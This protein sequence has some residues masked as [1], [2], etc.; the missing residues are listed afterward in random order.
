MWEIL[1]L[2][3]TY[4]KFYAKEMW[5]VLA[6]HSV[7]IERERDECEW[8]VLLLRCMI[9]IRNSFCLKS[10]PDDSYFSVEGKGSIVLN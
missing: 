8:T 10:S 7:Y 4:K 5:L 9:K 1:I 6:R 2:L 3:S